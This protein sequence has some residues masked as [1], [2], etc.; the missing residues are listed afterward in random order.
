M[1][2]PLIQRDGPLL[3]GTSNQ[4]EL[5]Q[6]ASFQQKKL[7]FSLNNNSSAIPSSHFQDTNAVR[8]DIKDVTILVFSYLLS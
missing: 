8:T 3:L 5:Y 4:V 6:A 7:L 2:E 1:G